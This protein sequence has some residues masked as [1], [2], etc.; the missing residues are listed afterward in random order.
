[1]QKYV[2]RN[3]SDKYQ[4]VKTRPVASNQ[5]PRI[6]S[7]IR[8]TI[9][10]R[11]SKLEKSSTIFAGVNWEVGP[12]QH[13]NPSPACCN[14]YQNYQSAKCLKTCYLKYCTFNEV[15]RGG[16]LATVQHFPNNINLY[17]KLTEIYS[18]ASNA[19]LVFPY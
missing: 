9:F 8:I 14:Q 18:F 4:H 17:S 7:K 3:A 13:N 6:F 16:L 5:S 1:M 15:I 19:N 12:C 2:I 10:I 11:I